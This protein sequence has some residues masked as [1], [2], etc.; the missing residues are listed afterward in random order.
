[1]QKRLFRYGSYLL[2]SNLRLFVLR[3]V[4]NESSVCRLLMICCVFCFFRTEES[5]WKH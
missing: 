1:M 2:P 3:F 4:V 5:I